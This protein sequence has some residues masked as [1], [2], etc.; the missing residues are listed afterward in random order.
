[1]IQYKEQNK[2]ERDV[3]TSKPQKDA[4]KVGVVLT[5]D[6]NKGPKIKQ[7][8]STSIYISTALCL[9]LYRA[10]GTYVGFP[11]IWKWFAILGPTLLIS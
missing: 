6:V 3:G 7:T 10:V 1:M 9:L 4:N 8:T 2:N 5:Q 11:V